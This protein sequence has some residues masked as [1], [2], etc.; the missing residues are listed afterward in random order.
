MYYKI[1]AYKQH[2]TK[3]QFDKLYQCTENTVWNQNGNDFKFVGI[4]MG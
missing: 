1:T 3:V 2:L 4:D